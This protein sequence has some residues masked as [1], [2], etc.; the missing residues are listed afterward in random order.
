MLFSNIPYHSLYDTEQNDNVNLYFAL[1]NKHG[2]LVDDPTPF[3]HTV[4]RYILENFRDVDTIVYP[5]SSKAL[6]Q[7][8]AGMFG[9]LAFEFKKSKK[10]TIIS[11]AQELK[12]NKLEWQSQLSRFEEMGEDFQIN[13]IKPNQR[14]KY[15]DFIFDN[16]NMEHLKGQSVLL[17]D[18]SLFSGSTVRSMISVLTGLNCSITD[19]FTPFYCSSLF[20]ST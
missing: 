1:K 14:H 10:T 3:Y 7:T 18:D 19:I 12:W 20:K 9:G 4:E 16:T 17:L 13:K 8:I 6:N 2:R 11:K 15:E 5:E